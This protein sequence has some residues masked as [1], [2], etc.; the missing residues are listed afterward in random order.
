MLLGIREGATENSTVIAELLERHRLAG[1][2]SQA[3]M[4]FVID[5]LK[6]AQGGHQTRSSASDQPGAKMPR[7]QAAQTC[8]TIVPKKTGRKSKACSA[9]LGSF[10]QRRHGTHQETGRMAGSAVPFRGGSLGR[11]PGR[12]LHHSTGSIFRP[13]CSLLGDNQ[14]HRKP[15]RRSANPD[16]SCHSLAKRQHGNALDGLG[17]P[18]HEKRFNKIMGIAICGPWKPILNPAQPAFQEGRCVVTS[19]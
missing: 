1:R 17:F 9:R 10:R 15:T 4:P 5:G 16:P 2:R 7:P 14:H 12:V 3:K 18:P 11:R 8:S 13:P 6:G 19:T